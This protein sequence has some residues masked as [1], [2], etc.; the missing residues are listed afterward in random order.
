M[1][2]VSP[3]REIKKKTAYAHT[4]LKK[5]GWGGVSSSASFGGFLKNARIAT[6]LIKSLMWGGG[7]A[8]SGRR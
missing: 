8:L 2:N 5:K 6:V 7:P 1:N 3:H 4:T